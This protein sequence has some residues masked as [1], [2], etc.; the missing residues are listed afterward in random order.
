MKTILTPQRIAGGVLVVLGS[1]LVAQAASID[2]VI[3][4]GLSPAAFPS[5]L[6]WGIVS[7][8]VAIIFLPPPAGLDTA[9][10]SASWWSRLLGVAFYIGLGALAVFAL[11]PLGFIVVSAGIIALMGIRLG[12]KPL[13]LA[14][15]AIAMPVLAQVLFENA[16]GVPLAHGLLR[17]VLG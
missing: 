16:F 11:E 6:A 1:V 10:T 8:G 9:K 3:A 15:T 17:G 7:L 12:A 4:T 5:V 13:P 2:R 14:L